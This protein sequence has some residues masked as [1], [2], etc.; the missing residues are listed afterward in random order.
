MNTTFGPTPVQLIG[1]PQ[2]GGEYLFPSLP[3]TIFMPDQGLPGF[4]F[5][6][7]VLFPGPGR[8][9]YTLD[10]ERHRYVYQG[11]CP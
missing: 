8:S 5:L 11:A 10:S 7:Q 4:G 6:G 3:P 9:R 2:D 1:G